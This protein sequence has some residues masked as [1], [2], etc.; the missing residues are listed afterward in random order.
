[1]RS[2][3][4]L[5]AVL[6]TLPLPAQTIDIGDE[7]TSTPL[8][9]TRSGSRP[10]VA[11]V[12]DAHGAVIAWIAGNANGLGRVY[13]ARIDA[14]NRITGSVHELPV[15]SADLEATQFSMASS[16]DALAVTWLEQPPPAPP[17]NSTFALLVYSRL[18]SDFTATRPVTLHKD[19][20]PRTPFVR[21]APDGF[22]LAQGEYL[23]RLGA[24][25]SHGS[26]TLTGLSAQDLTVANGDAQIVGH[27]SVAPVFSCGCNYYG[28]TCPCP[29]YTTPPARIALL[30]V[31]R[32][33]IQLPFRSEV[34]A[35]VAVRSDETS[36]L[37]VWLEENNVRAMKLKPS[38]DAGGATVLT[39]GSSVAGNKTHFDL[40]TDGQRWIVVW[41]TPHAAGDNDIVGVSI[42]T[43]DTLVP[44][45]IAASPADEHDASIS[46]MG[47]GEF[48]VAYQSEHFGAQRI[49]G[50]V[51][52][53][54]FRRRAV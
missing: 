24:D 38:L 18:S 27:E 2:A 44:F 35:P 14:A 40:A 25:G 12:R 47:R 49:A 4:V 31:F 15:T 28:W 36:T 52:K 21:A 16:G 17:Y 20:T 19:E 54:R 43:D 42:E 32:Q 7:V 30:T 48:L 45:S 1:M 6:F 8:I 22:W 46:M 26:M 29:I 11:I 5:A 9:A 51:V 10:P 23:W 50:R 33:A 41:N 53:V 13:I 37:V 39:L 3:C 34:L